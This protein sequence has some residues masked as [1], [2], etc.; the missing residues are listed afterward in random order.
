MDFG[1][2]RGENRRKGEGI[3]GQGRKRVK[4]RR[5]GRTVTPPD[6]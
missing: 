1:R 2:G 5:N 3:E 4:K 6:E